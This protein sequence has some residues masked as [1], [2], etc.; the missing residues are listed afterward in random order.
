[1]H[2]NHTIVHA[3]DK[4]AAS[5]FVNQLLG[6]PPPR[7]VGP[8]A[9]V[10]VDADLSLDFI[11]AAEPMQSQHYAFLVTEAEFDAIFARMR[12]RGLTWWADP[13][14]REVGQMNT[15]DGGHGVYLDDPNGHQ[16]EVTTPSARLSMAAV[17][18]TVAIMT[19]LDP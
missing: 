9:I 6:L 16:L 17:T 19:R 11:D 7:L 12:E 4:I 3:R 14:R 2:L 18:A 1:M 13:G 8:F 15:W 10:Q 5:D